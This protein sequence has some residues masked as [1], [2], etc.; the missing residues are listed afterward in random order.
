MRQSQRILAVVNDRALYDKVAK[1]LTRSS[2]EVNRVPSGAGALILVGNLRYNLI[3][4][5]A[6]LPDIDLQ[7]FV[8]AIRTFDSPCV[9]SSVVVL[10]RNEEAARLSDALS[11]DDV[12]VVAA[13]AEPA[14]VQSA[15]SQAL[16]VAARAAARLLVQLDA[17]LEEGR[18]QRV[19]QTANISETGMLLSGTPPIPHGSRVRL[20]LELPGDP[21]TLSLSGEVVRHTSPEAESV[22]GIGVRFVE[23]AADSGARLREFLAQLHAQGEA[24]AEEEPELGRGEQAPATG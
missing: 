3:L 1:P 15:I 21:R 7:S 8:A 23:V 20:T 14:A 2:F 22:T 19:G 6:P 16:G 4:V 13:S 10:A 11:G 12:L 5:E 18:L 24:A 9:G 17:A